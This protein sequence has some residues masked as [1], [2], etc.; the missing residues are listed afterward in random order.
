MD[1]VMSKPVSDT[2]TDVTTDTVTDASTDTHLL[3]IYNPV[4]L[5]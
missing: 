1:H 2:V 5:P 4:S 3:Y